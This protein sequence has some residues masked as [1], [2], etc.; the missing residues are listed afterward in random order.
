[1][2]S[3]SVLFVKKMN[4]LQM[5]QKKHAL[6]RNFGIVQKSYS[7]EGLGEAASLVSFLSSLV[8]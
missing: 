8:N 3:C 6:S 1:M 7:K 5:L 2:L 4:L